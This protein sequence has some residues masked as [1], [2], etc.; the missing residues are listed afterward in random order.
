[1]TTTSRARR[2][3]L[4]LDFDGTVCLG[5]DPVLAYAGRVDAVLAA[6]G[7]GG[8][9]RAAI[10]RAL[11]AGNLLAADIAF[12]ETG[13]PRG[14]EQEP[15]ERAAGPDRAPAA[16]PVSWP[17]QDGYQLVQL[18]AR[19]R[20][21]SDADAGRAFLSAR[22]DL[23]AR[24][25]AATDVHAPEGLAALIE[26]I[27]PEVG[28]VL[29]TNAPASA[30][31]PWLEALG[32]TAAFDAVITDSRK[33]F[34]MPDVLRRA[35]GLVGGDA[36]VPVQEVLSVGDIW[37]NDHEHIA[38]LGGTTL[39]IDRFSTGLGAPDHRVQD[40]TDAEAI[41]RRWAQVGARR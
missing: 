40:F 18:L 29:A 19:Q 37:R 2:R 28:V 9:V 11:A 39:L 22:G 23:L 10:T 31:A 20:G 38:A 12:D 5:D 35:C 24:G 3:L 7:H 34:G 6:R 15:I 21:L 13:F 32:L 1:M 17:V 14:V 41:I 16:H 30:F 4:L 33:P 36:P 25:L 8:G 27:R 26:A